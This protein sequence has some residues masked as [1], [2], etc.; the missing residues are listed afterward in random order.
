MLLFCYVIVYSMS[1]YCDFPVASGF[2]LH[3]SFGLQLI[4]SG[5][6]LLLGCTGVIVVVIVGLLF[7]YVI[8]IET[9]RILSCIRGLD[10]SELHLVGGYCWKAL[11][12]GSKTAGLPGGRC[13]V[14]LEQV[15]LK[16]KQSCC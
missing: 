15:F 2:E 16:S 6:W 11:G 3:H 10:C 9:T 13:R 4:A 1:D 5:W 8:V 14:A 7:C 12:C